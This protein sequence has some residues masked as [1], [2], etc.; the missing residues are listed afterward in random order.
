[1][2]NLIQ[3]NQFEMAEKYIEAQIERNYKDEYDLP[4]YR[5]LESIYICHYF[6]YVTMLCYD[7]LVVL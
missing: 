5:K 6:Y 4:Y 2:E 1:V 7:R 3:I